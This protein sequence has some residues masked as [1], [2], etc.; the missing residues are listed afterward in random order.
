MGMFN[1]SKNLFPKVYNVTI[2]FTPQHEFDLGY[3][4]KGSNLEGRFTDFPYSGG[5]APKARGK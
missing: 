5:K 2:D 1:E 4:S 3:N